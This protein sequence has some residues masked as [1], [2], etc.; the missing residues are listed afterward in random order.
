MDLG[1]TER[2]YQISLLSMTQFISICFLMVIYALQL[3]C[4][5]GRLKENCQ[6][7]NWYER[8]YQTAKEGR[9][10]SSDFYVKKCEAVKGFVNYQDLDI[11]FKAAREKICDPKK[12]ELAGKNGQAYKFPLCDAHNEGRMKAAYNNGVRSYCSPSRAYNVGLSGEEYKKIC[13]SHLEE[14]FLQGYSRGRKK[15]ITNTVNAKK[16]RISKIKSE[17]KDHNNQIRGL[18][19]KLRGLSRRQYRYSAEEVQVQRETISSEIQTHKWAID[20]LNGERLQV[21]ED[22]QK[23]QK[24]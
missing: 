7:T 15:Y 4:A 11:G 20:T 21:Q 6:S 16:G 8:G 22:I 10:T 19:G 14:S 13:P 9:M 24:N 3:G 17:I 1:L 12:A 23:L 2:S 5:S 18:K